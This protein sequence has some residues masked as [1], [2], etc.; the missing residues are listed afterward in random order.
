[1]YPLALKTLIGFAKRMKK[2]GYDPMDFNKAPKG[3]LAPKQ[4]HNQDQLSTKDEDDSSEDDSKDNTEMDWNF[5][6]LPKSNSDADG[7]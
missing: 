6:P 1:M 4:K 2:L 7:W 3:K 5:P